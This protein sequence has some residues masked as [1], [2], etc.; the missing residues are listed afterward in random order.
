MATL[1]EWFVNADADGTGDGTTSA[2]TGPTS[3][4]KSKNAAISALASRIGAMVS[5]DETILIREQGTT[6]DTVRVNQVL[7][8]QTDATHRLTIQ[9][10]VD[11]GGKWNTAAPRLSFSLNGG[12]VF[13]L[14]GVEHVTLIGLQIENTVTG[15]NTADAIHMDDG[16]AVDWI[17]ERV[18]VRQPAKASAGTG[19]TLVAGSGTVKMRACLIH[20]FNTRGIR[21][22]GDADFYL[23]KSTLAD[24]TDGVDK[25]DDGGTAQASNCIFTDISS[26]PIEGGAR[27]TAVDY[28]ATDDTTLG[29]SLPPGTGNRVSQAFA[30]VDAANHDYHLA[31]GDTGAKGH[32]TD[33]SADPINPVALDIDGD[34]SGTD[35]GAD[36]TASGAQTADLASP[37]M[38][39]T[40]RAPSVSVGA[41]TAA[42]GVASMTAQALAVTVQLGA[43]T[44]E[45][46][47]PA[48]AIEAPAVAV[49]PGPVTAAMG[50]AP[51]SMT[52]LPPTVQIGAQSA[53]LGAA[54]IAFT[55]NPPSVIPGPVTVTTSTPGLSAAAPA[56]SVSMGAIAVSPGAAALMIEALAPTSTLGAATVSLATA[57]ATILALE[58]TVTGGAPS[59]EVTATLSLRP[60][61]SIDLTLSP[62]ISAEWSRV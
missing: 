22:E 39:L 51:A 36:Q 5:N 1:A 17:F 10:D 46:A 33:L 42:A 25:T 61:V 29:A 32:G 48:A 12:G 13:R 37:A 20:T 60:A 2:L 3:A 56:T 14:N 53:D 11:H 59:K 50:M 18:I 19:A 15:A 30:F 57:G 6:A 34:A 8:G 23:Y 44:A 47:A 31:A 4:F 28:C 43:Q 26:N 21:F 41:V 24:V 58:L 7:A 16:G 9:S 52:A 38:S 55:T 27:W 54:A 40:A 35:I 45:L 62:L 49:V